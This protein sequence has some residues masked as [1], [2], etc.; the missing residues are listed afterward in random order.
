MADTS[1]MTFL[2]PTHIAA[3]ERF[4]A[5][6]DRAAENY[7]RT[8]R[9][10]PSDIMAAKRARERAYEA[11]QRVEYDAYRRELAAQDEGA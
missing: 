1:R 11:R 7:A 10:N 8:V 6:N 9:R 3:L 5:I 2:T 4:A